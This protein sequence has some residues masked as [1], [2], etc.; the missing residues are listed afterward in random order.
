MLLIVEPSFSATKLIFFPKKIAKKLEE[1]DF[2]LVQTFNEFVFSVEMAQGAKDTS[3]KWTEIF[4]RVGGEIKTALV[5][6]EDE[7]RRLLGDES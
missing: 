7:F 5:D 1:I 6:L 3:Q 2:E 4:K